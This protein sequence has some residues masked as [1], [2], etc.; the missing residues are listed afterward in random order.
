MM[1]ITDRTQADV[2]R[3][4]AVIAKLQSGK[5]LTDAEQSEYGAG[6]KGCYNY[7]DINRVRAA[8]TALAASLNA[9]GYKVAVSPVLAGESTDALEDR[10]FTETDVVY[11]AQWENYINNVRAIRDAFYTFGDTG[12][13]PQPDERIN[14]AYANNIEKVLEDVEAL[15]WFMTQSYRRCGALTAGNNAVTLPLRGSV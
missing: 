3:A 6:L 13:L 15:L 14:Y 11:K 12:P 2:N 1:F 10:N 8:V 7:T 4:K 9:E 5:A